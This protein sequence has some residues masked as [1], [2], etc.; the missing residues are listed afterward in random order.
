MARGLP[1]NMQRIKSD[2]TFIGNSFSIS[3]QAPTSWKIQ[4]G[5]IIWKDRIIN[6]WQDNRNGQFDIYCNVLSYRNPDSIVRI[7]NL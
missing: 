4:S 3:H 6:L 7:I 2:R 5:L 1:S